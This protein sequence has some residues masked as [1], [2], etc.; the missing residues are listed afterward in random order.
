MLREARAL[1]LGAQRPVAAVALAP[2]VV[3]L[4]ATAIVACEADVLRAS[5]L[6]SYNELLLSVLLLARDRDAASHTKE[7]QLD[8]APHPYKLRFPGPPV[9]RGHAQRGARE[10]KDST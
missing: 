3:H 5:I 4:E 8:H 9:P 10:A 2:T 7:G 1:I 6:G